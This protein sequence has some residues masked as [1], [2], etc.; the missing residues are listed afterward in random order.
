MG[1]LFME[2]RVLRKKILIVD[3]NAPNRDVLCDT[4]E[5]LGFVTEEAKDGNE[6]LEVC[7]NFQPDIILMDLRMPGIDGFTATEQVKGHKD[8]AHI[9]VFAVTASTSDTK[10]LKKRCL[11]H[12]FNAYFTKPYSTIELLETLAGELQLELQYADSKAEYLNEL[13]ILIPS[14]DILDTIVKLAQ[15][16]NIDGVLE[17]SAVIEVMEDGKDKAF[18]D[19]IKQLA[20]DFQLIEIVRYISMSRRGKG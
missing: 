1:T 2:N 17:Q 12:G 11:E 19:H 18:A 15:S 4:L 14:R 10:K 8:Y 16:G 7:K 13:E 3:D 20:D 6:V 5:H 9:P